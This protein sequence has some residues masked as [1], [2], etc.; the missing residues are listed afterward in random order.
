MWGAR[1]GRLMHAPQFVEPEAFPDLPL[2][3]KEYKRRRPEDTVLYHVI[4]EHYRSFVAACE[5]EDRPLPG[6]VRREFERYLACGQLSEGFARVHCYECGYD[7]LVAFSCRRRGFC[8]SCLGRRM[9]DG[10][11]FLA[12]HVIG[13][14]PIRHWVLSL[15]PPLRYLLAY[16]SSLVT[17]VL[18]AFVDATFQFLR[19]KGKHFLGLRSVTLAHPGAVTAIQRSSSSLGLNVHFHSLNPDGVFVQETPGETARLR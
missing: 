6:F 9:N 10:A 11:A 14:T 3:A 17:E 13:D 19:W 18:G 4:Q 16:D 15:P 2:L 8:P 1:Y 5:E 12:D 7:R